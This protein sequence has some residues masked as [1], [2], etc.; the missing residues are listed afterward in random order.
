M[1]KLSDSNQVTHDRP[2]AQLAAIFAAG[3]LRL[4]SA[5]GYVPA[6]HA[7]AADSSEKLSESAGASAPP[8]APCAHRLT[9]A[10]NREEA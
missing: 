5:P 9:P 2:L 3:F 1:P 8:S 10:E 4:R 7:A 6:R